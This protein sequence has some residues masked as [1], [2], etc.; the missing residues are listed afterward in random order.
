MTTDPLETLLAGYKSWRDIGND[1][2]IGGLIAEIAVIAL[3][4]E[5]WKRKWLCELLAGV[6]VLIGVWIEVQYS[7]YADEIE[8]QIR[9][10]SNKQI[11]L[12]N[13][14]AG[15]AN[16]RAAEADAHAAEA[17]KKAAPPPLAAGKWAAVRPGGNRRT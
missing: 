5:H 2:L 8:R 17:N 1:A 15:D 12:L 9:Q 3:V 14:E 16:G 11:A 13:K 10:Q 7:G 4:A 6:I